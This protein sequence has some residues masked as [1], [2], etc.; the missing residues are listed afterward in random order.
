M[1]LATL[2]RDTEMRE[3]T[4]LH[5]LLLLGRPF[6]KVLFS[7]TFFIQGEIISYNKPYPLPLVT[8]ETSPLEQ[9]RE[10]TRMRY[11]A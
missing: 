9:L 5:S 10:T 2:L 7:L 4:S 8:K 6:C 3:T 11:T 1:Q